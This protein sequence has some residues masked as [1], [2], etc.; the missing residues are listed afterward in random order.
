MKGAI[1]MCCSSYPE[2]GKD[3]ATL[4]IFSPEADLP[5]GLI[6]ITL[7]VSKANLKDT[8]LET[9]RSNLRQPQKKCM[10]QH[11]TQYSDKVVSQQVYQKVFKCQV[12]RVLIHSLCPKKS[13]WQFRMTLDRVL[14]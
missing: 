3:V 13:Q 1:S 12:H 11:I 14:E 9:L 8:V 2:V 6:F 5:V 7:K 4:D 10:N